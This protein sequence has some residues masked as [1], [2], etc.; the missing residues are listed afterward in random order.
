MKTKNS[1]FTLIEVMV[2]VGVIA[3]ALPAL[4]F[5]MMEQIDGT[6]YLRDKLQAQWVA[7]NT[8]EEVRIQNHLNGAVPESD[9]TGEEELGDRKWYWKMRSKAFEQEEL[10]DI[11]G[12]EVSVWADQEKADDP[13]AKVVAIV[14]KHKKDAIVRPQGETLVGSAP[15]PPPVQPPA[16]GEDQP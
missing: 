16:N 6:A 9:K 8:L 12:V 2:A 3:I 4:L 11:Y 13:L 10:A 7:E 15:N 14:R 1:G 5:S